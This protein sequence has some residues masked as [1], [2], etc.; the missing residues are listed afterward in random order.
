[1]LA[2]TLWTAVLEET[3]KLLGPTLGQGRTKI[4][5]LLADERCSQA[6][7]VFL[8]TTD[9]GRTPGPPAVGDGDGEAS[10][11]SEYV[12]RQGARGTTRIFEEEDER[13]STEARSRRTGL[14]PVGGTWALT[15]IRASFSFT[16]GLLPTADRT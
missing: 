6:V 13:Y 5:E 12:G 1:V 2:E 4:A 16:G 9:V 14:I 10:K 15:S 8:A 7:L 11:A 3:K